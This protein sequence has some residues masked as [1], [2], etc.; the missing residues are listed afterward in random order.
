MSM[1]M[2]I[3]IY[4]VPENAAASRSSDISSPS[5]SSYEEMTQWCVHRPS[6]IFTAACTHGESLLQGR[7]KLTVTQPL[8][9]GNPLHGRRK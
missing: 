1:L 2:T 7:P 6:R 8:R 4:I 3:F 5:I 9:Y